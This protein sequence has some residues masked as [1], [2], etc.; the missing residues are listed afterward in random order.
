MLGV[1]FQMSLFYMLTF[2]DVVADLIFV[3]EYKVKVYYKKFLLIL[4]FAPPPKFCL[5]D[6]QLTLILSLTSWRLQMLCG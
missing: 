4:V 3:L 5:S 6:L 2:K 1:F